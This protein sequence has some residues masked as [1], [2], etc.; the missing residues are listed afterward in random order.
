MHQH[1]AFGHF[2]FPA[3]NL[4]FNHSLSWNL[5]LPPGIAGRSLP[6]QM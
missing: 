1:A 5:L 2:D 3:V 4:D 6:G